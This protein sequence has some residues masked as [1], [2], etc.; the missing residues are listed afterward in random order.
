MCPTSAIKT[1]QL[2]F[3]KH[4]LCPV[5]FHH[6]RFCHLQKRWYKFPRRNRPVPCPRQ[7]SFQARVRARTL[8]S[9]YLKLSF[10]FVTFILPERNIDARKELFIKGWAVG[11]WGEMKGTY[12]ETLIL[13]NNRLCS[14]FKKGLI[15]EGV[16]AYVCRFFRLKAYW[17]C[18]PGLPG[19]IANQLLSYLNFFNSIRGFFLR[20]C[21]FSIFILVTDSVIQRLSDSRLFLLCLLQDVGDGRWIYLYDKDTNWIIRREIIFS[22]QKSA[23]SAHAIGQ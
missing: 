20:C 16:S 10:K 5:K 6:L 15:K 19:L 21:S 12:W 3:R 23:D 9:N 22:S 17:D 18:S 7:C 13:R 2:S 1:G 11:R 4:D 14:W 8:H